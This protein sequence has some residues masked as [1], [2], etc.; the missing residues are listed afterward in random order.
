MLKCRIASTKTEENRNNNEKKFENAIADNFQTHEN[1][2]LTNIVI[3]EVQYILSSM[4]K[5]EIHT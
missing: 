4:N 5:K 1:Y 3:P 2:D